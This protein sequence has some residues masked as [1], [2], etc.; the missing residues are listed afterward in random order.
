MFHAENMQSLETNPVMAQML[1]LSIASIKN[2]QI[3][4]K[5]Y[6]KEMS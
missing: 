4:M 2:I 5:I 1:D 6:Y 3:I